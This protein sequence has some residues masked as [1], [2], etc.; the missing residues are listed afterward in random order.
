MSDYK[1]ELATYKKNW[2]TAKRTYKE[3]RATYK[4]ACAQYPTSR[5]KFLARVKV[6]ATA[7]EEVVASLA[8]A[9][10]AAANRGRV[11]A[12]LIARF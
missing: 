5:D 10:S 7:F 12:A 8:A 9:P 6:A 4:Q 11:A 2:K 3:T 1:A